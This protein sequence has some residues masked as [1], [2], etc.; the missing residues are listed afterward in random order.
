MHVPVMY[1]KIK[2]QFLEWLILILFTLSVGAQLAQAMKK[3]QDLL[4][5]L[6]HYDLSDNPIGPD[7]QAALSFIQESQMITVLNLSKCGLN[8]DLVCLFIL[9]ILSSILTQNFKQFLSGLS[10]SYSRM[11]TTLKRIELVTK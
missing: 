11:S 4:Y 5:S 7:S 8:F 3:N 9:R 6:T 2:S 1:S 10:T